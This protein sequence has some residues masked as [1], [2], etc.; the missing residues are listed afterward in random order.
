MNEQDRIN[1]DVLA[2]ELRDA[3]SELGYGVVGGRREMYVAEP[4]VVI[5]LEKG[6]TGMVLMLIVDDPS[7]ED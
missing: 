7:R 1:R 4:V 2:F 3:L 5:E 6:D